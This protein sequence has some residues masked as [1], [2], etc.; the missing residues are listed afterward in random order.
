[1]KQAVLCCDTQTSTREWN[2]QQQAEVKQNGIKEKNEA[3][4]SAVLI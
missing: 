4:A 1:M 3:P 2:T